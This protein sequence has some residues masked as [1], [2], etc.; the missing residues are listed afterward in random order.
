V[1]VLDRA[2]ASAA[3]TI[4]DVAN[5][6]TLVN[7]ATAAI[8]FTIGDAQTP[9]ASLTLNK[10][11]SNPALVSTNA[12]VFGGS[13][14]NR[15][16][17]IT[18]ATGQSGVST[19]TISVSDGTNSSSDAF[20]LTVSAAPSITAKSFTNLTSIGIPDH[21][22]G[23]PYPS[24]INVSGVGGVATNVTITLRNL[25]HTWSRDIDVLLVGPGGQKVMLMSDAGNGAVKNVT[26][27]LADAATVALPTTALATGTFRPANYTD[28]SAGGDNFPSPAPAAPYGST[29]SGFAGQPA[30]G[31]W[32]LYVYD[33]G[34][35]DAGSFAG[36]WS[37]DLMTTNQG[38][39]PILSL[40]GPAVITS[41]TVDAQGI[42]RVFA[43]GATNLNYALEASSELTNWAQ[44]GLMFNTSGTVAFTEQPTTNSIRFYR[45]RSVSQ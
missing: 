29:L 42:V 44:I 13:G 32:S 14:S 21:G 39:A 7:T 30:N 11:S 2:T 1:L 12:I 6:S 33:D 22:A 23:T 24:V 26:L 8:P 5:Q 38:T 18:P 28:S 15:T 17:T 45:I 25:T 4:S 35:G 19:I 40:P 31:V 34:V 37:I 43:S 36:G 16:V 20:V 10:A 41:L 9:A 27:T 3:P